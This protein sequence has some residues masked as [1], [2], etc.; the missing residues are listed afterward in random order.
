MSVDSILAAKAT[1]VAAILKQHDPLQ[2][3]VVRKDHF[4]SA[5]TECGIDVS[6]P[7]V[8]EIV[9]FCA[10]G[11]SV[12]Y[13]QFFSDVQAGSYTLEQLQPPSGVSR[14]DIAVAPPVK[15]ASS[16]VLRSTEDPKVKEALA[17]TRV[18]LNEARER[19]ESLERTVHELKRQL[20]VESDRATTAE[21]KLEQVEQMHAG[22]MREAPEQAA[23]EAQ[24]IAQLD[25]S[26]IHI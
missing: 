13:Q 8:R 11:T 14:A 22:L 12:L 19:T 23:R 9:D 18:E 6:S 10:D 20:V 26:L 16:S 21:K 3:G 7:V 2:I 4:L 15:A 5:L 1:Q 24:S 25:L 17:R